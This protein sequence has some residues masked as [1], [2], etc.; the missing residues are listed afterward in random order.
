[1]RWCLLGLLLL[2]GAA[3]AASPDLPWPAGELRQRLELTPPPVTR[4]GEY[5]FELTEVQRLT[6]D[7][8]PRLRFLVRCT[9]L[10]GAAPPGELALLAAPRVIDSAGARLEPVAFTTHTRDGERWLDLV[11]ADAATG[12]VAMLAGAVGVAAAPERRVARV[13]LDALGRPL[14]LSGMDLPLTLALLRREPVRLDLS[15]AG[16]PYYFALDSTAGDSRPAPAGGGEYLTLRLHCLTPADESHTWQ[17]AN[18]RLVGENGL[19]VQDWRTIRRLYR[20]DWGGYMGATGADWSGPAQPVRAVKLTVVEP[21]GPAAQAGLRAGDLLARFDGQPIGDAF[22]LGER[23]RQTP[24]GATVK[25]QCWRDGSPR[26]VAVKLGRQELWPGL[27]EL[28]FRQGWEALQAVEARPRAVLSLWDWQTRAPLAPGFQPTA[29]ELI[30]TRQPEPRG[31]TFVF[32]DVP[33]VP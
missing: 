3:C 7:G 10:Q 1:M 24:A 18:L 2:A 5:Q 15:P 4:S 17:L 26:Q 9:T 22:T 27:D 31:T 25:L 19:P 23:V 29:L 16:P 13:D 8:R 12:G 33:L 28:E 30:F 11:V 14:L 6:L 21:G 20:P 32:A